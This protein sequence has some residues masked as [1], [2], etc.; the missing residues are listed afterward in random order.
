MKRPEK[1]MNVLFKKLV[2]FSLGPIIGALISFITIPITT[3]Y[4]NPAEYG[5]ASM[6][7]LFQNIVGT[8]LFLGIDQAYTREYHGTADKTRLLQNAL[9][10][11]LLLALLVLLMTLIFPAPLAHLLFGHRNA[12]IPTRLFGVMTVFIVLERFLMLSVRMRERAFEYSLLAILTKFFVLLFTV[13]FIIF[14]RRDFLTVVYST[15]FGQ[16][17]GDLWLFWRYRRLL[18]PKAFRA[19]RR[20][21]KTLIVFGLPIV[22]ATSLSSL[23]GGLDRIALRLWS[24]FN[25]IG[26]FSATLKIAAVLSVFQS[27]FTGFWVP[28]AYR[29]YAEARPVSYFERVSETVLLAMSLLAVSIF[30]FKEAIVFLLSSNYNGAQYLVGLLCLQPL[31]YTISET[32]CLGI[33][34]SKRSYLNIWVGLCALTP[35]VLL[36]VLLV[37]SFG[38]AGAAIASAIA[39]LFFFAART[40]LSAKYWTAF[41]VG[42]HY[43]VFMILLAAAFIN[44]LPRSWILFINLIVLFL[45]LAVQ[46]KTI[47]MLWRFWKNGN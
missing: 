29:W 46:Q 34:F 24:D 30:I 27:G 39:Y 40:F 42:R 35:A 37:P 9:L 47:R 5:K 25:Q 3:Y 8:F 16:I 14:I 12:V 41:P 45:I 2:G 28:I 38:A 26:I 22:V 17:I 43:L 7:L 4:I 15:V 23:L 13:V 36:D 33:V 20:L 44:L 19:D 18:N 6:F 21:L 11:P 31:I 32:T 1:T 10:L